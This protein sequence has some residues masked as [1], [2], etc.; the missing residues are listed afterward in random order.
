MNRQTEI[1]ES[2]HHIS[3]RVTLLRNL[4]INKWA[5]RLFRDIGIIMNGLERNREWSQEEID[6]YHENE[7]DD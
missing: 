3:V 5:H 6:A 1:Y 7:R 2:L 4:A